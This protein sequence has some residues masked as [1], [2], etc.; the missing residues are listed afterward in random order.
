MQ[1]CALRFSFSPGIYTEDRIQ[2]HELDVVGQPKAH[3][4]VTE[5]MKRSVLLA[6]CV[7]VISATTGCSPQIEPMALKIQQKNFEHLELFSDE[8]VPNCGASYGI[9]CQQPLYSVYFF[10]RSSIEARDVCAPVIEYQ[11]ELELDAYSAEGAS[12]IAQHRNLNE[13]IDFCVEGL[14]RNLGSAENHNYYEGTVLYGDGAEDGLGKVTVISRRE[15]GS[16][17]VDFSI[18]RDK[19]RIGY[20]EIQGEPKHLILE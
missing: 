11:N 15:D 4:R 18:G 12:E 20:F 5:S 14:E 9:P 10:A 16:Y 8:L 2:G 13:V 17:F 7:V 3:R 1:P 19:D 6:L